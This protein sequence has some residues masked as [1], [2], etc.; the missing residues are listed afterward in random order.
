MILDST[1]NITEKTC[2]KFSVASRVCALRA[3]V[4]V[5]PAESR[6]CMI[7]GEDMSHSQPVS[8]RREPVLE[9][10]RWKEFGHWFGRICRDLMT[11]LRR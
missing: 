7:C 3:Y 1:E 4:R 6:K 10:L 9:E 2:G 11:P 5:G 8:E